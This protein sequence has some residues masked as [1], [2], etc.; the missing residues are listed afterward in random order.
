MA[1][2]R[3]SL[4]AGLATVTAAM[5][6]R[7]VSASVAPILTER[8]AFFVREHE[9]AARAL[10]EAL[11]SGIYSPWL[12]GDEHESPF[13]WRL[14]RAVV[15]IS[16]AKDLSGLEQ[17]LRS[18]LDEVWNNLTRP[19]WF[20]R[21]AVHGHPRYGATR[22]GTPSPEQ[23]LDEIKRQR[24]VW[25]VWEELPRERQTGMI[26]EAVGERFGS[27][28]KAERVAVYITAHLVAINSA[29]LGRLFKRDV[30][31]T[32]RALHDVGQQSQRDAAFA[33]KVAGVQEAITDRLAAPVTNATI[34]SPG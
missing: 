1:L 9:W 28:V 8:E 34:A 17:V 2:T 19:K 12:G 10:L 18:K 22:M 21:P 7:G 27:G 29:A 24:E 15:M 23:P 32:L 4:L 11:E 13:R 3:R 20:E 33:G 5:A 31:W 14:A 25:Q 30:Q 26:R 16:E 6:A